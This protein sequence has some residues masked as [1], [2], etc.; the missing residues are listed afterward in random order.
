MR[1]DPIRLSARHRAWLQLTFGVLFVSGAVWLC[2]HSFGVSG[3]EFGPHTHPLQPWCLR[4]HGAT[5]MLF[6]VILGSLL[7]GHVRGAWKLRRN[8]FTGAVLI[9]FNAALVLTGYGLYYA[10]GEELRPWISRIHWVAGLATP[11]IIAWHI[12]RGKIS[13]AKVNRGRTGFQPVR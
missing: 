6:L 4:V 7:R 13:A 3:G 9:A 11:A 1:R 10:G 8:R 2:L 5:A 12:W